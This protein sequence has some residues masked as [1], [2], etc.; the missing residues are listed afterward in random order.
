ME[1]VLRVPGRCPL[2]VWRGLDGVLRVSE[3]NL[4]DV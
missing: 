4:W 3:G 1:I 2:A